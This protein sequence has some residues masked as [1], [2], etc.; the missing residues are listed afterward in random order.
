[1]VTTTFIL[2]P[3]NRKK[4]FRN[5]RT[6]KNDEIIENNENSKNSKNKDKDKNLGINFA[7]VSIPYH[8]S[9]KIYVDT[10]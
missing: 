3:A 5:I 1:M 8:F 10:I 7:Q 4:T 6:N 2:V 9:R